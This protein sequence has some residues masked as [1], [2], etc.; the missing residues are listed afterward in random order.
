MSPRAVTATFIL[1]NLLIYSIATVLS[2]LTHDPMA[3]QVRLTEAPL[4][5]VKRQLARMQRR[6]EKLEI[7]LQY[8]VA[9]R[10]KT[11]QAVLPEGH[12]ITNAFQG[13]IQGNRSGDLEAR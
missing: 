6:K 10:Q 13:L 2:Y 9:G 5:Q 12:I 8:L 3:R 1:I 7:R 4:R 11:L